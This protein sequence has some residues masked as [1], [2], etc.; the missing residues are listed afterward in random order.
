MQSDVN[1]TENMHNKCIDKYNS[2]VYTRIV[3]KLDVS[4]H[5]FITQFTH[6]SHLSVLFL[7]WTKEGTQTVTVVEAATGATYGLNAIFCKEPTIIL[8][9]CE[10]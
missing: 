8:L 7:L 1:I 9:L 10:S 3:Y 5:S 4:F 6:A 2:L